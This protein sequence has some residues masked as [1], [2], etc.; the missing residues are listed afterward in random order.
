[1]DVAAFAARAGSDLLWGAHALP[2]HVTQLE[3]L[4]VV[5]L[6]RELAHTSL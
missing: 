6:G 1:M 5:F 2:H 3:L 4:E